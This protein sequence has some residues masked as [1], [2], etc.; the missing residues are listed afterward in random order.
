M[1]NPH[2]LRPLPTG[3]FRFF[4]LDVETANRS[5]S[6]ICQ[7]GVACVRSD[8]SMATWM[9]YIDPVTDDWSATWVHH[10]TQDTVNG[11]P[12][13]PT[14]LAHLRPH[15][16]GEIVFQHSHFDQNAIRRACLKHDLDIPNWRWR[17]SVK[18]ARK[19]WP[20]LRGNGGFGLASLKDYLS[21][22]FRHHD[23]EE[24]ARA[25][26]EVVLLAEE[27]TGRDFALK[28]VLKPKVD[29]NQLDLFPPQLKEPQNGPF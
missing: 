26:A 16:D 14:V 13:F 9:S 18:V 24:D 3:P 27:K 17:D 20:Q 19:A 15:L 11:A 7:I 21:L 2:T 10:I 22:E 4:A 25:S 1:E 12:D 6:S 5:S 28:R 29:P 8:G 23:G